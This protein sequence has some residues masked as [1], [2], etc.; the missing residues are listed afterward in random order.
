MKITKLLIFCFLTIFLTLSIQAQEAKIISGKVLDENSTPIPGAT[1][2]IKGTSKGTVT[3]FDGNYEIM[4]SSNG[5]L[6]FSF[7]GYKSIEESIKG[8]TKINVQLISGA[9]QLDEVV[10]TALGIK[11]EEK[12]LGYAVQKV[13]GESLQ[14]VRGVDVGTS[15][16]GKVAGL[17]VLNS[18][19]FGAAPDIQIRGENPL[20]VIDGVPYQNMTLRDIAA[21]DIES[22]SVLKGATASALY[23]FRGQGGAIMITTKKSGNRGLSVSINSGSMFTA[24]YLAIPELQSTF[25]RTVSAATNI[26]DRGANGSWGVPMD[27]REVIQ[28]NPISKSLMPMPYLPIG[29]DNFKNFLQQGYILN[30]NISVVHQGETGSFRVSATKVN[31][32][33]QY[34]NSKFNKYTFSLGGE[35]KADKF[36]LSSTM[37][38]SKQ[39]SPNLGFN[40]YR[41]Y[42]PM[43]SLLIW[44]AGDWDVRD[45]RDY[46]LIKN[47][48]QNSSYTGGANNPYFDRNERTRSTDKDILNGMLSLSYDLN[49]WLKLTNR[50]GF[51][52]YSN[53]QEVT[54]SK[55]SFQGAGT[56]SVIGGGTEIWGENVKGSYNQGIS[57][58][59]SLNN[60]LLLLFNKKV[61]D[62]TVDGLM[63]GSI[64]YNQDEGL[65]ALTRGGLSIPAFY[66]LKAS[67]LSVLVNSRIYKKQVNSLFGRL[68]VSY[69]GIVFAET[70]LRND[71][72]STLSKDNRS[73]LYP[74]FSASFVASELLPKT[75]WLS[76]WKIRA[77]QTT[78]KKP[79]GIYDINMVYGITPNAWGTL[80]SASYPGT[81][82]GTDLRAESSSTFEIGTAMKFFKKRASLD[83]SYYNKRMYDFLKSTSIS[84]ASGYN[85]NYINI[86]EEQTRKG[87]EIAADFTPIQTAD[88]QWDLNLNWSKY[89]RYYTKLDAAFSTDQPWVK[90]GERADHYVIND[91]LKDPSGNIIHSNGLPL[92]STFGSKFGNYDP[93]WIWGLS[94]SLKYKNWVLGVSFD[95]RVGGLAQ[96]STEMYMWISG[97]HP[98]SVTPERML[99]ATQPGT[100]NY[101]SQGVKVVSGAVSFDTYGNIV[102]DTRVYAPND[103]PVTYKNYIARYHKGTAWGGSPSPV[104]TYST[105]FLK[106]RE[107]SITYNVPKSFSSKL[108]AKSI[109]VSA[110]GQNLLLWSKD[111]KYS[112]PDGGNDDFSDP[113]QRFLGFNL[114]LDF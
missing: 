48:S 18:T 5:T 87:I 20:L 82:R 2:L 50:A 16:T 7:L 30:N 71:W 109:S 33:G 93:D 63:G 69:K 61:N 41:A 72:S 42:D 114:K 92:Y 44:G 14:T 68:G 35:M 113:S 76:F 47:E 74:S 108:N 10:V 86:D 62:F 66:S 37:A 89:A 43:Y 100:S 97:S 112:D 95:G 1:I 29:K 15:L 75:D 85:S 60:D 9:Q 78:A 34:P 45:Y 40:G 56:A 52:T 38:Y 28:W 26:Y 64:T 98:D 103:I 73:Y 107:M 83:V 25:G 88:W 55:G 27:G 105:T 54:I 31:N 111:F 4:A 17:K 96:T 39:T 22:M 90:V 13:A 11:R 67:V 106:M 99:D 19:E 65:E 94:S 70:T 57:R 80:T 102:T 81:I 84:P 49:S 58:G 8:R 46:W 104:D 23:G 77:S 79:A 32:V 53:L 12:A 101:I 59:Y 51:D 21:D 3:G 24:G 36:S 6:V 110:I 91:Y